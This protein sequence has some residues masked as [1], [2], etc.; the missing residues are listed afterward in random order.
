[1]AKI[2]YYQVGLP[3]FL[4]QNEKSQP[5]HEK[6]TKLEATMA[7]LERLHAKCPTSQALL[8]EEV[9]TLPQEKLIVERGVDE[10]ALTRAKMTLSRA[11]LIMDETNFNAQI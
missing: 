4:D 2:N 3:M 8:M 5:P 6:M 7:K 1:M 10:L 9:N 11:Q